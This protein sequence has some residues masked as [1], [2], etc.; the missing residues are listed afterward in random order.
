MTLCLR[1]HPLGQFALSYSIVQPAQPSLQVH[2]WSQRCQR[3]AEAEWL[4]LWRAKVSTS[5][6]MVKKQR[7]SVAEWCIDDMLTAKQ[8]HK[9]QELREQWRVDWRKMQAGTFLVCSINTAR[10]KNWIKKKKNCTATWNTAD[11]RGQ[12]TAANTGSLTREGFDR[13]KNWLRD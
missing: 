4:A 1:L 5:L 12:F 10:A 3:N 2:T 9:W 13:D 7:C 6:A 8:Q 11:C